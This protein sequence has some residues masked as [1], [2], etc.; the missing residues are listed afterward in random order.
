MYTYTQVSPHH[1]L[2]VEQHS[3]LLGLTALIWDK[4]PEETLEESVQ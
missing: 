4:F 1:L 2:A 3:S